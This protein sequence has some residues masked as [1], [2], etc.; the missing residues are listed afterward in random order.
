MVLCFSACVFQ[1]Q[2]YSLQ[3]GLHQTLSALSAWG[4]MSP[5]LYTMLTAKVKD[6]L[7]PW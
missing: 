2:N 5:A 6:S 3:E 1:P 7:E 4:R